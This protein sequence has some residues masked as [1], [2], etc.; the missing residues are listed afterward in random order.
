MCITTNQPDTK[1]NPS[2]NP[3]NKQ[4]AADSSECGGSHIHCCAHLRGALLTRTDA[5]LITQVRVSMATLYS[6]VCDLDEGLLQKRRSTL[7]FSSPPQPTF[8]LMH[9]Q[10]DP[11]MPS[12]FLQNLCKIS[13]INPF[14][15]A[16]LLTGIRTQTAPR[17]NEQH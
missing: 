16:T 6:D 13:Q 4:H 12:R 15:S 7:F 14:S 8:P 1:S 5:M 9:A 11:P 2:A 10:D 3:T 17:Q